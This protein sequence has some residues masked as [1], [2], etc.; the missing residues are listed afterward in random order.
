MKLVK[1]KHIVSH[2]GLQQPI[3]IFALTHILKIRDEVE[4][5]RVREKNLVLLRQKVYRVCLPLQ[6]QFRAEFV[7]P[8]AEHASGR[9]VPLK[10]GTVRLYLFLLVLD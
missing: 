9:N 3:R 6:F 5:I 10:R 8:F 1:E 7:E 4:N 2:D